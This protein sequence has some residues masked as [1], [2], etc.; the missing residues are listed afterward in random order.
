MRALRFFGAM[1]AVFTVGCESQSEEPTVRVQVGQLS[2]PSISDAVWTIKMSGPTGPLWEETI[3]SA[4]YGDGKGSISYVGPCDAS[5]DGQNTITLE[6]VE[7][8]PLTAADWV[9]PGPMTRTFTCA[10][11]ADTLVEFDVTVLRDANMGFADIAVNF[12]DIFCSAKFDCVDD[13]NTPIEFVPDA[14]GV[15][16][17]SA[18]LAVACSGDTN[19]DLRLYTNDAVITCASGETY[20]LSPMPEGLKFPPPGTPPGALLAGQLN[21]W[22]TTEDS[23]TSGVY[24]SLAFAFGAD[25]GAQGAHADCRLSFRA[26]ATNGALAD[27]TLPAGMT[28]PVI[29]WDVPLTNAN[30]GPACGAYA[31]FEGQE[32][33]PAYSSG[34][35]TFSHSFG[36][37][38]QQ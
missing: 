26:T 16:R 14:S 17:P 11:N 28:Y 21:A 20:T 34:G 12:E 4:A 1:V 36:G 29:E 24:L 22:G 6:L 13:N 5:A 27:N 33:T 9:S 15:R 32:V 31:L 25:F 38:A 35:E 18:V 10:S 7:L 19:A 23:I 30:S 2:L 3:N 8:V 37:P